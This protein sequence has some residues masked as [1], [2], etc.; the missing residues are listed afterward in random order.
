MRAASACRFSAEK[1]ARHSWL[2]WHKRR[3]QAPA[4][5]QRQVLEPTQR[6]LLLESPVSG[7]HSCAK[8]PAQELAVQTKVAPEISRASNCLV[9]FESAQ[10]EGRLEVPACCAIHGRET[11]DDFTFL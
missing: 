3:G 11:Q 5:Q 6:V 7:D 10:Q 4:C 2:S 1:A 9:G 8:E